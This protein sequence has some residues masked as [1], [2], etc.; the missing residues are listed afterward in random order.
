MYSLSTCSFQQIVNAGNDEQFVTVFFQVD[1]AFVGVDYL[2]QVDILFYD[3]CERIFCIVVLIHFYD[4]VQLYFGFDN[5]CCKNTSGKISSVRYKIYLRIE[6]VLQLFDRLLDFGHVLMSKRFVDTHV[7]VT[8]A[9]VCSCSGFYSSSCAAGYSIYH[10]IIVQHQV[11]GQRKQTKLNTC[12]KASRVGYV[13]TL[14]DGTAIQFRKPVNKIMAFILN[15]VVHRK[16]ND[17]HIF[18]DVVAFYELFGITVCCTEENYIYCI[19][20]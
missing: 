9:E 11:F 1:K 7:I 4:F 19:K 8:P 13:F 5:D 17:F 18:R 10:N 14:A 3:V 2:L 15:A 16:V 20:R 6:T 12:S